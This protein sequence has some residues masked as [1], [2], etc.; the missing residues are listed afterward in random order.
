MDKFKEFY[1]ELW[2]LDQANN[3]L[4]ASAPDSNRG[5]V[6]KNADIL[7]DE[8]Y[9]AAGRN[10]DRAP[11]PLFYSVKETKLEGKTYKSCIEL[12]NNYLVYPREQEDLIGNNSEEDIERKNFLD[13]IVE[14]RVV[15][16]GLEFINENLKKEVIEKVLKFIDRPINSKLEKDDFKKYIEKIWFEIYTNYYK[17]K[18]QPNCSGFE[19]V[20]VGEGKSKD[21]RGI[22]G[23]HSWIKFYLD[24]KGKRV[25]FTGYNYDILGKEG[26]ENPYVAT[27]QMTWTPKDI[28]GRRV[29]RLFKDKGGFFVGISPECQIV[30][31]T[32]LILEK[33]NG[34]L[35]GT[36]KE[37]EINNQVYDLVIYPETPK[38]MENN[39]GMRI[40]SFFP[41]YKGPSDLSN[42]RKYYEII[43]N[44]ND[45]RIIAAYL[46]PARSSRGIGWVEIDNISLTRISIVG[47]K[48]VDMSNNEKILEGDIEPN[49]TR[50]LII[51]EDDL[52]LN[53]DGTIELRD[54]ENRSVF[55]IKYHNV[56]DGEILYFS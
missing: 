17:G 41:K 25:D 23:Y 37:V 7:I 12:L 5:W 46:N 33:M 28:Y 1:E 2:N 6:N 34:L 48:L 44:E 26:R 51:Y 55:K 32:L 10:K 31:G 45:I 36:N 19:H 35:N 47:W 53:E 20:F 24:E 15:E 22:G 54:K 40:R 43:N 8:Q 4:S 27:I 52:L 9:E 39:T 49:K 13:S 29:R 50:R 18:P 56:P 11:N 14:T 38:S 3:G 21:N 42:V 16:R 30:M